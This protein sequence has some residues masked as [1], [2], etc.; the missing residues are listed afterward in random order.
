MRF[1]YFDFHIGP[2]LTLGVVF[3]A[4]GKGLQLFQ[5]LLCGAIALFG[6]G[7][8]GAQGLIGGLADGSGAV[9]LV[10]FH[11]PCAAT[12]AFFAERKGQQAAGI[13]GVGCNLLGFVDMSEGCIGAIFACHVVVYAVL[14]AHYEAFAVVGGADLC[15]GGIIV[16]H[17]DAGQSL[18]VAFAQGFVAAFEEGF[19]CVFCRLAARNV[20]HTQKW[21]C[22]H[23]A[24]GFALATPA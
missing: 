21:G 3:F 1:G 22:H 9:G 16:G 11:Y 10:Y 15:V 13:I 24:A 7:N 5:G 17:A 19:Q 20:M 12:I 23:H 4:L 18:K 8:Q 2:C 6:N 14:P